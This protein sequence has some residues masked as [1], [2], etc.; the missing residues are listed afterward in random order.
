MTPLGAICGIGP[1]GVACLGAGKIRGIR[2]PQVEPRRE[3]IRVPQLER[4]EQDQC[5]GYRTEAWVNTRRYT[6]RYRAALRSQPKSRV[7]ASRIISS[8]AS[9]SRY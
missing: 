7:I 2:V 8:H 6:V 3:G 1:E 9:V 5:A 4:V